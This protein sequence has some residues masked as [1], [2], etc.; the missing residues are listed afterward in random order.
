MGDIVNVEL[1]IFSG[2]PD[3]VLSLDQDA[4][5]NLVQLLTT[6]IGQQQTNFAE[7]PGLGYRGFVITSTSGQAGL[8]SVC[9]VYAKTIS[10]PTETGETQDWTDTGG[11]EQ[12][13]ID[14]ARAL[15]FGD[16]LDQAGVP[17][18]PNV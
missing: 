11:A 7:P 9:N 1:S 5:T 13:L 17:G 8:P 16:I 4:E 14:Q 10:V 12:F 6:A 18:G 15:G 3:P 2:N